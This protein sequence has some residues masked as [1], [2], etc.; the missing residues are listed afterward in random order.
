MKPKAQVVGWR[1]FCSGVNMSQSQSNI[2]LIVANILFGISYTII[3]DLL[4]ERLSY[5]QLFSL[6]VVVGAIVFIP[7]SLIKLQG[8]KASMKDA[9]RLAICSIITIYG[10]SYLTMMGSC[11]TTSLNIA[12]ISTLGPTVTIVAAAMQHNKDQK[13]KHIHP[14]LVRALATP[15]LLLCIVVLVVVGDIK[16]IAP[17]SHHFGN[18]IVGLG[19]ISMGISTVVVKSLHRQYGTLVILGWYFAVGLLLLP[20]VVPNFVDG[21][22]DLFKAQLDRRGQIE[23]ALLPILEMVLPIYLLYRGSRN[24][25]PLHTAL[26]RYIQPIIALIVLIFAHFGDLSVLLPDIRT[27]AS[28]LFITLALLLVSTFIMPRDEVK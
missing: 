11:H 27:L 6:V 17:E 28:T 7:L 5:E 1:V 12:A 23:L 14:N 4:G 21:L 16:M 13:V 8:V 26:Y 22:I 20:W 18:M 2:S 3:V 19:V 10:W 24:L 9:L 25:T 15:L